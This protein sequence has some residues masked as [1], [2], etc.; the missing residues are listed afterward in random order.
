MQFSFSNGFFIFSFIAN[1]LSDKLLIWDVSFAPQEYEL[2][3][4]KFPLN[5]I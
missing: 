4:C 3:S 2:C 5:F 1:E